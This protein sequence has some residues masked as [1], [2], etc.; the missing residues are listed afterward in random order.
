[1]NAKAFAQV[2]LFFFLTHSGNSLISAFLTCMQL[3]FHEINYICFEWF[4]G[5]SKHLKSER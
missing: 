4:G 1:M 5:W 2:I 3:S